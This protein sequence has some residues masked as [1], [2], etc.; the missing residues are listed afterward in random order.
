MDLHQKLK[1]RQHDQIWREYCGFLDLTTAEYMEI[2]NRLM[3]EQID[4]YSRCELGRII[5]KGNKPATVEEFRNMVPLT[6]YDDYADILLPKIDSALPERPVTWIETTWEGG[7]HPVKVA[8]YTEGMI[9][10]HK[11]ISI[12]IIILATSSKK[13][14]FSLKGTE[15]FLY[16]MA[17]LPYLTGLVPYLIASQL[18]VTFL[19]SIEDAESMSFG[20]RNKVGFELGM[21]KGIDLFFG[22]SSVVVKIGE[23]F[24]LG[25]KSANKHNFLKNSP[26]MNYRL[27]TAWLNSKKNKKPIMPKDIWKLKGLICTGTDT[28][29]LKKIIEKYWGV[30]PLEIFGGTE[31]ACIATETWSKNGLVLFPDV[32]FYEFIPRVEFE[33]NLVD[34]SYVPN[35]YLLDELLA[36][37]EYELVISNFKGGAFARY[38]TGDILKCLSL[39]NEEENLKLPQFAFVDRD[40]RFID[41]AGFT[42]ISE[43]TISEALELSKLN[44]NQW[45]A[46]KETDEHKR[47]YLHLYVEVGEEG[48]RSLFTK[49][50]IKEHLSI[51]FR[52]LDSDFSNLKA[53]LG[54]DPLRVSIIPSGTISKFEDVFGRSLRK[55]NPSHFDVVEVLKI[56]RG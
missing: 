50:I 28:A 7:K 39:K 48:L 49:E 51:Y 2:Q 37:E 14:E 17:P 24:V 52:C 10:S 4:L 11:N 22:L 26:K 55:I 54:I 8:P 42:R 3:L 25:E 18:P 53:L 46:V 20:Q 19:P 34:P 44:L 9:N 41:I 47:T 31:P 32:D 6:K 56:A 21:Q 35:T 29:S 23:S 15:K 40:P 13:G 43:R 12:T 27:L 45:F 5:M 36:G 33:K 16:G 1:N 38:R 30:K